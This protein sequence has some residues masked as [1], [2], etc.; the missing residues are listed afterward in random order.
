MRYDNHT[1]ITVQLSMPKNITC[2]YKITPHV[3]KHMPLVSSNCFQAI[4]DKNPFM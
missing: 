2:I 4:Y 3:L 1:N